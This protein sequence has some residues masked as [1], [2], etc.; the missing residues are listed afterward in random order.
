MAW[1]EAPTLFFRF[2]V[3][4][5]ALILVS[6]TEDLRQAQ[7]RL[8]AAAPQRGDSADEYLLSLYM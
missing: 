7:I 1:Y 8:L 3:G 2:P 6:G 5:V 4:G